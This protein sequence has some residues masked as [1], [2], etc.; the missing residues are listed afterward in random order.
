MELLELSHL[1]VQHPRGLL[2]WFLHKGNRA[3]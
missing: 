1:I 3:A 2:R